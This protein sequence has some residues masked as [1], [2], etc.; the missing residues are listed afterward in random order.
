MA[1]DGTLVFDTELDA[2]GFQTGANKLNNLV[3][4][5]GIFKLLEKG[6]QMVANSVDKAM[7][8]I[9]TMEQFSRV[10][11]TMT[12]DVSATN[13]ALAETTE[14]VSGTAY[15]LDY[16]ARAVQN[17]TSRGMEISKSTETVRA[18]GDAV[19][20]Y[21]DGSNAAFGS[22]TDALSKMQTKG[23]VT[24]EH[25]EMLL[26][27]GIPA[28][29][30]YADA[31]GV[32]ASDVT[33]IMSDGELSAMD[34][35]NTM[36][37]AMTTGTSRFPSLSGAAKEAGAS[38]GATFDN[39]GAAITRGVQ[40]IILSIDDTQEALNRPTMRDAIKTFGSLFE[41]ALKA[42]AAVLPPVIE[43]VD[44]LA[45]SVAGLMLAYGSNK[46]MQAFTR[47]QELA[48]AAATAADMANKLL[49]P[50]LDKKA[51]AEARA[52]AIAKLGKT[53]TEEQIVAEMAS[54]G[55]IT[56]K[57]FALGGMSAGLSLSTVASTLLTAATT[58]LS[59]AIKA[60]LGPVGLVIAA[61][62][63]LVT[64]IAALIKWLTRDTEAFKQQSEAVEEL[65][66]AQENLQQ[67]TDSSA[68]SH[69]D[70]V[71]SLKAEADASKKLAAQITELSHK[72]NKSAADKALLKSYVEQLNAEYDG[73]N[74]SYS[75]EG[76]YLNL[77]TEQM[78]EY[79][80]AKMAL[81]E[82]N[83]LIT[84]QNELYQEEATLK[85]NLQELDE[86]QA[87]L[88]AQLA[89]KALKQSEYNELMEQLNAT[90]EAYILQ[91]EDIAA[92]KS[93]VEAQIAQTDTAAAQSIIDNAEAVAAAQEA[94][95]ERRSN[96][97]QSYTDAATNMFDK[98]ETKSEVSVSQMIA[99]LRHNQEALQQWSENLVTLAERGLDQ[100]L[101]QQL[102][103]AGPESAATV[104]ELVRASDAQLSELSEVFANGSE[105]A[106]KALMTE[107]GLPEVTNSGSDM[108]DDIAAGVDKNQALEDATL[109]LIQDTK[110]AA[111]NQVK[112]SNF[113]SIGQQMINGIISGINAGTSG[114]VSAMAD[115]AAAAYN[116]AKRKLDIRSPSHL[117]ENMI[118]LMT[119]KGWTKGVKK[120]EGGLVGQMKHSVQAAIE[121]AGGIL[122]FGAKASQAVAML[123]QG[124]MMNN[125]QL[126]TAGAA[127]SGMSVTNIGGA[128]SRTFVQN[129]YSH[130]A[131]S[132]A[133][134]STEAV[135]AM[136][137]DEWRLP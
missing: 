114:L 15:G 125:L 36:N 20:F 93:E 18:W 67:S 73:L 38:W 34:F 69:Q 17:F 74:L 68:K 12:G 4:G 50:T 47:Q 83:A 80:D 27:A 9:D 28:I 41:K 91:E 5:L 92:R 129:I 82:S 118:G 136:E 130:D 59:A 23:N 14:I 75:E 96:A 3:S 65:A 24:M 8:R 19:A 21:G 79:I 133:E 31:I 1:Y 58:A 66:S 120:G 86:K 26:N 29:E 124:V 113:P 53:A 116:A 112:A 87:E 126:A 52:A 22:V 90:R 94:E 131:L 105:A 99:N 77:N 84:R 39:M 43:N 121:A 123:R 134:M 7:G 10:M 56:A 61:A 97:L 76:D 102:R 62:A 33:Q 127:A 110:T 13:E 119:M 72:E 109:Q 78:N 30:M 37:L 81:D 51:L 11:T 132:P 117:F 135:A 6:F 25:M 44:I 108:V 98:I 40:S 57:T 32:T 111:E 71:K 64:G 106:T 100:G 16:A 115:A 88:D 85:Q 49:I 54:T 46:V 89:D 137:R 60:L 128:S 48:A 101:L 70:N 107:L 2:N 104:A 42:V 35:I 55:V 45:I 63:L 95:M 103:D 122:S